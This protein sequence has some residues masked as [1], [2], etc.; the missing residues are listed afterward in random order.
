MNTLTYT[1][2]W[3]DTNRTAFVWGVCVENDF[4]KGVLDEMTKNV[5]FRAES[6]VTF[7][8]RMTA[9]WP[10]RATDTHLFDFIPSRPGLGVPRFV[11]GG[12][13]RP[14]IFNER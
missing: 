1:V 8:P 12:S 11:P 4:K 9:E 3:W 13:R 5:T 14:V 2:S 7:F 6:G 10:A